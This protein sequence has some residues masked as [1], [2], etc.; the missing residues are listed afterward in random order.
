MTSPF[1]KYH[2]A[3]Y[4]HQFRVRYPDKTLMR[5]YNKTSERWEKLNGTQVADPVERNGRGNRRA[6]PR[7]VAGGAP[8]QVSMSLSIRRTECAVSV[9]S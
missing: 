3:E 8:S 6:H 9:P 2:L 5:Y 7:V 4:P 1:P